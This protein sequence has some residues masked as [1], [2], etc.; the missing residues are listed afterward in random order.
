MSLA[1]AFFFFFFLF[2]MPNS[3]LN[4]W[5]R[6]TGRWRHAFVLITLQTCRVDHN[7]DEAALSFFLFSVVDS[8]PWC[9]F[10][11]SLGEC[12]L[13]T[14]RAVWMFARKKNDV[15]NMERMWPPAKCTLL[16]GGAHH[17]WSNSISEMICCVSSA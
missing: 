16:A 2:A 10:R 4:S 8:P 14:R 12:E 7:D 15:F 6:Q 1:C 3:A 13:F 9:W 17:F 11:L 5:R